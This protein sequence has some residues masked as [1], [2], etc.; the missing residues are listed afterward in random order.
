MSNSEGKEII[1]AV[2]KAW[3]E[4]ERGEITPALE[5]LRRVESE[6]SGFASFHVVRASALL[7]QGELRPSLS[8]AQRAIELA[9][10]SPHA[11]LIRAIA[12]DRLKSTESQATLARYL[13]P[14]ALPSE[15]LPPQFDLDRTADELT[16]ERPL[17]KPVLEPDER[18]AEQLPNMDE[19]PALVSETLAEI[20]IRQGKLAEAKKV[21]IQLSRLQPTRY[22][23][24]QNKIEAIDKLVLGTGIVAESSQNDNNNTGQ[25]E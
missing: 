12:E 20:M 13:D 6:A 3:R 11:L 17:V 14:V 7:Q 18:R 24:F 22:E 8:A 1:E 25:N 4:F 15:A 10:R 21:Y 19:Q 23:Y 5:T 16:R 9:P 2:H